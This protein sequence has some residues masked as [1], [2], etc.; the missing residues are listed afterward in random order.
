MYIRYITAKAGLDLLLLDS[1]AVRGDMPVL[2]GHTQIQPFVTT[3]NSQSCF[4]LDHTCGHLVMFGLF[5]SPLMNGQAS[6]T[7]DIRCKHC[8]TPF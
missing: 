3:E 7:M 8:C 1:I 4:G 2:C 5:Q 6:P